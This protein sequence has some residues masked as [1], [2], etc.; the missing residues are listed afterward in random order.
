MAHL[1]P[2]EQ[3]RRDEPW[4]RLYGDRAYNDALAATQWV[5]SLEYP[6][7]PRPAAPAEEHREEEDRPRRSV[8]GHVT[9]AQEEPL[10]VQAAWG[11]P[12]IWPSHRI[13]APSFVR[14]MALRARAALRAAVPAEI[15]P[16]FTA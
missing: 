12:R 2:E 5:L 7:P 15:V 14:M 1:T 16:R 11:H 4:I 13:H 10:V 6:P 3:R 8:G 9:V